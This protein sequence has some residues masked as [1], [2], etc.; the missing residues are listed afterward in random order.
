MTWDLVEEQQFK[1]IF[2]NVNQW[3]H[4]AEA[5][6]VAVTTLDI[7]LLAVYADYIKK[8]SQNLMWL[9]F[10]L[11]ELALIVSLCIAIYSFFP[12][13]YLHNAYNSTNS[14]N[15]NPLYYKDIASWE[16]VSYAQF[17]LSRYYGRVPSQTPEIIFIDYAE[18]IVTNARIAVRKNILFRNAL[19][20][21]LIAL[22]CFAFACYAPQISD[23]W[24][25][26]SDV[27]FI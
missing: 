6:N 10:C 20:C 7:A 2:N 18:E 23:C 19:I 16:A 14:R 27:L 8:V 24:H 11:S 12:K 3:L 21:A 15:V 1:D 9:V 26:I 4:F 25:I 17:I 13:S 5:K 22:A